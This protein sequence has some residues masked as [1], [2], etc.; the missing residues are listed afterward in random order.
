[1]N[2]ERIYQVIFS[3][4]VTEKTVNISESANV[5]SFK[6]SID[7]TKL[8]IKKAVEQ[9]F[10]VKVDSVRTVKVKGKQ[11]NFGRRSGRRK[12][13]KKAYVKLAD[14]QAIALGTEG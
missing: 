5:Q 7:A 8:E 6:V 2:Q 4:Y 12:D 1:M 3:P 9:L 13:W 14:G 11:K 10:D